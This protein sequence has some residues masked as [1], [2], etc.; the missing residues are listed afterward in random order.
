MEIRKCSEH[1]HYF[2]ATTLYKRYTIK[3][4]YQT[5]SPQFSQ[6]VNGEYIFW[7]CMCMQMTTTI[8]TLSHRTIPHETETLL[9]HK[10]CRMLGLH[11]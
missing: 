7:L 1:G 4:S 9:K 2:H 6:T 5:S 10:W 3:R 11:A 8:T